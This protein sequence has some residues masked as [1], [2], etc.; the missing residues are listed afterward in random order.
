MYKEAGIGRAGISDG[1]TVVPGSS[2]CLFYVL[3][4]GAVAYS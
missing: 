4:W 1:E 2:V 3:S